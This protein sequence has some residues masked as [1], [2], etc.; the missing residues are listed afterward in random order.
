MELTRRLSVSVIVVVLFIISVLSVYVNL[1]PIDALVLNIY[2][3]LIVL[4]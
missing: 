3:A 1:L 4:W 2:A